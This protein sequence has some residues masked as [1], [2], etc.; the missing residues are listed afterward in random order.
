MRHRRWEAERQGGDEREREEGP[1]IVVLDIVHTPLC[2]ALGVLLFV[3]PGARVE[4]ARQGSSIGID[5]ELQTC[6]IILVKQ[7]FP[8]DRTAS[9]PAKHHMLSIQCHLFHGLTYTEHCGEACVCMKYR[10]YLS[11]P[12]SSRQRMDDPPAN[13]AAKQKKGAWWSLW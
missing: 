7:A 13:V 10:A 3:P 6:R 1:T 5:P 8:H 4:L 2:K 12:P 9:P 11:S